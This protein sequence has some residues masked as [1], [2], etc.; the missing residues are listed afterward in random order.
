MKKG[1]E[2]ASEPERPTWTFLTN[3]AH[4]LLCISRDPQARI[5]DLAEL[6]GITERAVQRIIVELEEGGYL[7]REKDGRRNV[8]RV[9]SNLPLRHPVERRNKVSALLA[10]VVNDER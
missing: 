3:H 1:A 5:R 7:V 2:R 9:R 4:V 8:Y 10:L 6:V